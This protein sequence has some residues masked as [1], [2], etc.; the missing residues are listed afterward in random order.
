MTPDE[1]PVAAGSLP[2]APSAPPTEKAAS[3]RYVD[4]A[5]A[6]RLGPSLS[7]AA[8]DAIQRLVDALAAEEPD[9]HATAAGHEPPAELDDVV[10]HLRDPDRAARPVVRLAQLAVQ[11]RLERDNLHVALET[12]RTIGVAVGVLMALRQLT[13]E[14]AFELLVSISQNHNRKLREVAEAVVRTGLLPG[15]ED[16]D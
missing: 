7:P 4:P 6:S 12:N 10:R 14:D 1:P 2:S 16:L 8:L 13:H 5:G 9:P 15:A 3:G 11:L